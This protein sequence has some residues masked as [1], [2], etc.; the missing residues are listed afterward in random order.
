MAG[1]LTLDQ[2][3]LVRP[4]LREQVRGFRPCYHRVV[5]YADPEK[6]KAFQRAW[7]AARRQEW[8]AANGPC[9]DCGSWEK[10][11][12]DHLDAKDKVSH[13]VWSW[14]KVRRENEL[15]KCVVRCFPCHLAK[16]IQSGEFPGGPKGENNYRA[17]LTEAGVRFIRAAPPAVSTRELA[18][19]LGVNSGTV[20][21]ARRG[22]SWKHVR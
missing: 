18:R 7:L 17:R 22:L 10:L 5:P 3:T 19:Q 15:A 9:T 20:S 12:V 6:Q 8:I 4:Q 1:H 14:S 13:R 21:L 11:Q 16:T 2:A